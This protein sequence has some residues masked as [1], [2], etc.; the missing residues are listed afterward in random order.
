M[1]FNRDIC[2]RIKAQIAEIQLAKVYSL[3]EQTKGSKSEFLV[4]WQCPSGEWFKIKN[5]GSVQ[6][7]SKSAA[8]DGI[9]SDSS[10]KLLRAF[11]CKDICLVKEAELWSLWHGLTIAWTLEPNSLT[12][13][14][15][16]T[17]PISNDH[18]LSQLVLEVQQFLYRAWTSRVVH[19]VWKVNRAT[20]FCA[21]M[22]HSLDEGVQ[23][24][25]VPPTR[26]Q[27]IIQENA[28]GMVF[29]R[30]CGS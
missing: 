27:H 15:L 22:G 18:P 29:S 25:E 3:L 1:P 7:E 28:Y 2:V 23:E 9:K 30:L 21:N 13:V 24:L 8:C 20:D 10:G 26:L 19:A 14:Q 17:N 16:V 6:A 4:G 12:A 5:Y 11:A